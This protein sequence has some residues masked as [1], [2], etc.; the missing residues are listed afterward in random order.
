MKRQDY[1]QLTLFPEDSRASHSV[2]PG[3]AEARK[4]TV[5]SGRKCLE[6][7]RISG[8][9]GSLVKMLLVSSQWR[10]TRCCLTWKASATPRNRLL[11][12]LVPSTP[13]TEGTGSPL[14]PTVTAG[15]ISFGQFDAKAAMLWPT[16]KASDYK[17]SGPAGSK[18]AE[19]DLKHRNLKGVVMYTPNARDFRNATAKEWDNPKNTRNLNRQ[20]AKLCEGGTSVEER[21]GQLNPTWVE[22]LM[23][24]PIGWTELNASET[25]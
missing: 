3:S 12:R 1:E 14:L 9:L 5:T 18:S 16:V 25:R 20:I 2:K 21:N 19:H 7:S 6:L 4:M 13:R 11:F 23:G 22:W 24:Y 17:G 15:D 10:S 8:P